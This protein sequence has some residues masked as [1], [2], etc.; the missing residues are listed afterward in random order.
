MISSVMSRL[1][2]FFIAFI[3]LTHLSLS[4]G[5]VYSLFEEVRNEQM[6]QAVK[7]YNSMMKVVSSGDIVEFSN[8]RSFKIIKFLG[9]GFTSKIFEIEGNQVIRLA[10]ESRFIRFINDFSLHNYTSLD[11]VLSVL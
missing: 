9:Q 3:L 11:N 1:L 2:K 5:E 10:R 8:G 7:E 6:P 4:Y